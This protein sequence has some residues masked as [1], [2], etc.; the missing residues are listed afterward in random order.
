MN[1]HITH[2]QGFSTMNGDLGSITVI[3]PNSLHL[4]LDNIAERNMWIDLYQRVAIEAFLPT[5]PN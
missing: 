4:Y 3:T 1:L 2:D 5:I